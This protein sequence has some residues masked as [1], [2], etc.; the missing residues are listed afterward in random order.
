MD[1]NPNVKRT[2]MIVLSVLLSASKNATT[3]AAWV[4]VLQYIYDVTHYHHQIRSLP[5]EGKG[6]LHS[7]WKSQ[8]H[9]SGEVMAIKLTRAHKL[10]E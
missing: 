2:R 9:I 10:T 8:E 4:Q 5:T 1:K 6:Q 7:D 3:R